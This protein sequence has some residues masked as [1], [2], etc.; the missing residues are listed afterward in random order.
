MWEFCVLALDCRVEHVSIVIMSS[1]SRHTCSSEVFWLGPTCMME[2]RGMWDFRVST[3]RLHG[4]PVQNCRQSS[5]LEALWCF[6]WPVQRAAVR[7]VV[8]ELLSS[9]IMWASCMEHAQGLFKRC[10]DKCLLAPIFRRIGT[11]SYPCGSSKQSQDPAN[12][13]E[14]SAINWPK[15][16]T[17]VR[18]KS[19]V[20]R[21]VRRWW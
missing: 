20:H 13:T 15:R 6:C 16:P 1:M 7:W 2:I 19:N 8:S 10:Y 14:D 12:F 17:V 9:F 11:Y 5:T 3:S 21:F 18:N 4:W